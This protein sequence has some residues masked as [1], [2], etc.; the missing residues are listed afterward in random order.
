MERRWKRLVEQLLWLG[1][2]VWLTVQEVS[3]VLSRHWGGGGGPEHHD[4]VRRK[5]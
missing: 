5:V 3:E 1:L 4:Q 2:R